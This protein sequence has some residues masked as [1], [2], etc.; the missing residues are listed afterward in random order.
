MSVDIEHAK[1]IIEM[2]VQGK[3]YVA[4]SKV[5]GI[6]RNKIASFC[7]DNGCA[8]VVSQGVKQ[9][10]LRDGGRCQI[11]RSKLNLKRKFPHK[12]S[13]TIDH[14]IALSKGGEH[15]YKNTQLACNE[16]NYTKGNGT[17]K[18]GEQLRLFG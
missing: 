7:K 3:S 4:I 15:S 13:A 12:L 10:F 17:A 5:I 2:R 11:C 6:H 14:I 1:I 18:G 16:C 9:L 8:V